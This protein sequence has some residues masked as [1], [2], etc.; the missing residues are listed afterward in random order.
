MQSQTKTSG[1][2]GDAEIADALQGKSELVLKARDGLHEGRVWKILYEPEKNES[3][4]DP[5]LEA[6]AKNNSALHN[7]LF[8]Q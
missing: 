1:C 6:K 5:I 8:G 2:K 4:Y 3:M 7:V